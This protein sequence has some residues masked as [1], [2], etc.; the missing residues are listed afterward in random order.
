MKSSPFPGMDPYLERNWGD[1]HLGLI[2]GIRAALQ[3]NLPLGLQ[4][5]G[6]EQVRLQAADD[7]RDQQ[8]G[9]DVAVVERAPGEKLEQA[10]GVSMATMKP[11]LVWVLPV[12]R[13]R[14][15]VEIID[16]AAGN[17]VVTAIEVPSPSN[18]AAGRDNREYRRWVRDHVRGRVN[19]VEIDLLQSPRAR[20]A[21]PMVGR[22]PRG[23][24]TTYFTCVNREVRNDY[25]EVYEDAPAG[26]AADGCHPVPPDRCRR[27]AAAAGRAGPRVPGGRPLSLGLCDAAAAAAAGR[28][29]GVGGRADR[30]AAAVMPAAVAA[31][32]IARRCGLVAPP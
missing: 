29:R 19:V 31:G 25:W 9:P 8:Y 20:L 7:E 22:R 11:V 6:Q 17:R 14:R 3:P 5:L 30:R 16:T 24:P 13:V 27:R 23:E 26:P 12:R 21:V 32:S 2:T 10:G 15:W 28:G 4:A 18:K 1:V